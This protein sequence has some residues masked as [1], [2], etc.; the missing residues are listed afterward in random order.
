MSEKLGKATAPAFMVGS[1]D[2]TG[3]LT[4]RVAQ[5]RAALKN[6]KQ[7]V[8]DIVIT[9]NGNDV[10]YVFLDK[11]GREMSSYRNE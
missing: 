9:G 11:E 2:G 5:L 6:I 10:T 8:D 1:E 3:T 4:V 7:S